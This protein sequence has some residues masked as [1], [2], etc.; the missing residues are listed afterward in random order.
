MGGFTSVSLHEQRA[1]HLLPVAPVDTAGILA[2][3]HRIKS[4]ISCR[5]AQHSTTHPRLSA[6]TRVPPS[7]PIAQGVLLQIFTKPLGDRSTVFVEIIQ[8][9]CALPEP[10]KEVGC[11]QICGKLAAAPWVAP[12]LHFLCL[13]ALIL[14]PAARLSSSLLTSWT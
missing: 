1:C 7:L 11:A 3:Q 13:Q 2:Q 14:H 9:L 5:T 4:T 10:P 6:F 12:G 8:R